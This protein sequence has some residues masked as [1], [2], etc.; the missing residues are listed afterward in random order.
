LIVKDRDGK[1]LHEVEGVNFLGCLDLRRADFTGL[2]L[3]GICLDD[4]DLREA[5]FTDADLY[6]ASGFRANFEGAKLRNAQLGGASLRGA[7]F[8]GADLRGAYI[9]LDNL[10]GSP[11]LEGADLTSALMDGAVLTGCEYD[12]LTR[13]PSGFNPE[14]HGMIRIEIKGS[15]QLQAAQL[16]RGRK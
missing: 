2:T 1:V 10:L 16:R 12:E 4:S 11:T 9:S 5:D 15:S 6:W 7:N 13:F 8:R 14:S 3:E